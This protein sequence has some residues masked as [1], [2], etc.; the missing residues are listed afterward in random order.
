MQLRREYPDHNVFVRVPPRNKKNVAGLI[1]CMWLTA[2]V[3][4]RRLSDG[5]GLGSSTCWAMP[6]FFIRNERL[7]RNHCEPDTCMHAYQASK[8]ATT[9]QPGQ[10]F[11]VRSALAP[12]VNCV[13][14]GFACVGCSRRLRRVL[15]VQ[16]LQLA[17]L[18]LGRRAMRAMQP[19]SQL[20]V[21]KRL[22]KSTK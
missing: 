17:V 21:F 15:L 12:T 3:C 2:V 14:G 19:A 4:E 9:S 8:Q 22:S 1:L 5:R 7:L 10:I 18:K 20:S 16:A 13:H 6:A 11:S